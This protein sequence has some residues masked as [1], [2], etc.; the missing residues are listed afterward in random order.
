[1]LLFKRTTH[2]TLKPVIHQ[3]SNVHLFSLGHLKIT[4][5]LW[6][7]RRCP[8]DDV[9]PRRSSL[10]FS[11]VAVFSNVF[12]GVFAV[13][14]NYQDIPYWFKCHF[15]ALPLRVSRLTSKRYIYRSVRIFDG[16]F[17]FFRRWNIYVVFFEQSFFFCQL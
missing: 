16:S 14:G 7:T 17:V 4:M 3:M 2:Y 13:Y 12:N 10:V 6:Y 8:I 9:T 1:M 5:F 15:E 11:V